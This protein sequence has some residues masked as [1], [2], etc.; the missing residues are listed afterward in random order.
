MALKDILINIPNIPQ[1][2]PDSHERIYI[3]DSSTLLDSP[4]TPL[5]G[6]RG[7]LGDAVAVLASYIFPSLLSGFLFL[8]MNLSLYEGGEE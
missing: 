4:E 7:K 8:K 2:M 5:L 3:S 6:R 1:Q